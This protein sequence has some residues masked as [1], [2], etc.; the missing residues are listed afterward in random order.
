VAAIEERVGPID[1]AVLAFGILGDQQ[2]AESDPEFAAS[3]LHTDF[4]AQAAL[5]TV[6]A[7]RGRGVELWIP[8]RC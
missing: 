1:V 2:R 8:R 4:I 7:E 6:L 5:L 3:V